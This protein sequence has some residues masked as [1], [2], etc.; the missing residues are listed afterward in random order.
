MA[1][2]VHRAMDPGWCN[3]SLL[4]QIPEIAL[5]N[6]RITDCADAAR[7]IVGISNYALDFFDNS[8]KRAGSSDSRHPNAMRFRAMSKA[9]GRSRRARFRYLSPRQQRKSSYIFSDI[10]RGVISI[11]FSSPV[12]LGRDSTC[13][14]AISPFFSA[15][16]LKLLTETRPISAGRGLHRCSAERG[17]DIDSRPTL[18]PW[19]SPWVRTS[20]RD[21]LTS[22]SRRFE[23]A[24]R[25]SLSS[26]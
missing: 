18:T 6:R 7:S 11:H 19:I 4:H 20:P 1:V 2:Q 15:N 23:A 8:I 16:P 17:R 24:K 14:I 9:F 12:S 10:S 3:A 21:R 25:P 5:W 22:V 26:G 13:E